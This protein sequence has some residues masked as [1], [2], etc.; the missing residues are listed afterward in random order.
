LLFSDPFV[1]DKVV[2]FKDVF[3][4]VLLWKFIIIIV[5]CFFDSNVV[6]ENIFV[7][8]AVFVVEVGRD[9]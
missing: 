7:A 8:V 6:S 4:V 5:V 9:L 1:C 2:L 3:A